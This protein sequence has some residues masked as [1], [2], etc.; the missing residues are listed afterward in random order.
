MV[1][2]RIIV[3]I[4][5]NSL[6]NTGLNTLFIVFFFILNLHLAYSKEFLDCIEDVPLVEKLN[7]N[8]ES[9]FYFDSHEG[10]VANVEAKTNLKKSKIFDFYIEILPQ[11][12]W[13]INNQSISS[14]ILKFSRGK[15]LLRI[16]ILESRDISVVTFFSFLLS[17]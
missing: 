5:K 12:G 8:I 13:K 15:E 3:R 16:S 2:Q 11:L 1:D 9:C 4:A 14:N 7:E 6:L 10:R 17:N